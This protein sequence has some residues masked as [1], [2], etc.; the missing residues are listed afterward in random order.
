MTTRQRLLAAFAALNVLILVVGW[1][2]LVSPQLDKASAASGQAQTVQ[3][4]IAALANAKPVPVKQPT[5]HTAD[6]YA[7]ETALPSQEDQPDLLFQ[8]DQLAQ[9]SDVE[10]LSLSPQ[11]GV[12]TTTNYTI[13]PINLS[14]G[15]TY[16]HLTQFL[17]SLR[18]LVAK[19]HGHLIAHGPLFAVTAVALTPG[20]SGEGTAKNE[21]IATVSM[22]AYYYGVVGSAVPPAPPATDTTT[23]DTTASGG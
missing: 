9:A 17:R 5:I 12:A 18:R 15:G 19:H 6:L 7:L 23:T 21:E 13:Q 1:F 22:A 2:M 16:F 20:A 11:T 4:Q 14:L 3:D 8:L 10:I